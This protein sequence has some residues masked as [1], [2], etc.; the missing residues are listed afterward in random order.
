MVPAVSV[1]RQPPGAAPYGGGL[2]SSHGY[3]NEE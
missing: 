2:L 1:G 3:T